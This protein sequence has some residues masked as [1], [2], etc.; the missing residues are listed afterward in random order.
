M[1]IG[2]HI[3]ETY[4]MA[5]LQAQRL[6]FGA[7]QIFSGT[8]NLLYPGGPKLAQPAGPAQVESLNNHLRKTGLVVAGHLPYIMNLCSTEGGRATNAIKAITAHLQKLSLFGIQ[9][10]VV[11]PGSYLGS[12]SMLEGL[13]ILHSTLKA[14]QDRGFTTKLLLE[15]PAGGGKQVGGDILSLYEVIQDLDP[16]KFGICI[17]TAHAYANATLDPD[18][19]DTFHH[20]VNK[21]KA[22]LCWVHFNTPDPHV[23]RGSHLDRHSVSFRRGK[24]TMQTLAELAAIFEQAGSPPLCMEADKEVYAENMDWLEMEGII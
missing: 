14:I 16:A 7:L 2:G 8:P 17:D 22:R 21:V 6:N 23:E 11:H 1:Q 9:Y 12:D 4:D 15:N 10:A 24:F 13:D 20:L 19:L 18:D 3:S 5:L